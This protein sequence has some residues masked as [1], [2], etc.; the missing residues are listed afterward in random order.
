MVMLL[1]HVDFAFSTKARERRTK[2]ARP[3]ARRVFVYIACLPLFPCASSFPSSEL[4]FSA[5]SL[6][7]SLVERSS[8]RR[9]S[10]WCVKENELAVRAAR[11]HSMYSICHTGCMYQLHAHETASS[12]LIY[13]TCVS[14][15]EPPTMTLSDPQ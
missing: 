13:F 11:E 2:S 15:C 10:A 3:S 8:S 12:F 14:T 5:L 4:T 7:A 9:P 6:S 1:T